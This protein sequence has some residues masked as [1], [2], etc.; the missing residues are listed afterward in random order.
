MGFKY[1][2]KLNFEMELEIMF[3]IPT[4]LI[5]KFIKIQYLECQNPPK[6][7]KR[8]NI[9]EIK[10][11]QYLQIIWKGKNKMVRNYIYISYGISCRTQIIIIL[12]NFYYKGDIYY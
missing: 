1:C 5:D 6:T 8:N 2:P 11:H 7:I 4:E 10:N 12:G 9:P 3:I